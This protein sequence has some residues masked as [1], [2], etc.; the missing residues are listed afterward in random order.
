MSKKRKQTDTFLLALSQA[1]RD[2]RESLRLT[3]EEV[4]E[5]ARLHRTYISDIERGARNLSLR[6]LVE[7]ARALEMQASDLVIIVEKK[8][9][10]LKSVSGSDS[11]PTEVGE[12]HCA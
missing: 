4:A 1:V 3:Q 9:A 12:L 7:L 8:L 6:S 11:S 10:E 2:R 5:R